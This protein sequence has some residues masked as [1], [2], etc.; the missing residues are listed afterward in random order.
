MATSTLQQQHI[1]LN[2]TPVE[3]VKINGAS[4]R[5]DLTTILHYV[6]PAVTEEELNADK[7]YGSDPNTFGKFGKELTFN[8]EDVAD[9]GSEFSL[10]KEGFTYVKHASALT[11]DDFKDAE[12]T[13]TIY[14]P[15]TE[16]LI[17]KV[18][19]A[20]KVCI[21]NTMTRVSHGKVPER[22]GAKEQGHG[23][24][25][26]VHVDQDNAAVDKTIRDCYPPA[27]AEELLKKRVQIVNV[28]RP[29]EQIY[30]DPFG[31]ADLN[32]QAPEDIIALKVFLKDGV[33]ATTLGCRANLN[34]HWYYKYAQK[35]D[36]PVLFLQFDS[37]V[38]G[39]C[40]GRVPHSA[41]KDMEYED[42]EPRRSIEARALVF[43]DEESR[44]YLNEKY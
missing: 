14:R 19:G 5:R 4:K 18:T 39:H 25:Y 28:W 23:Q 20:Y 15:E 43:Y 32:T 41:F 7:E 17:K 2:D 35:P 42:G 38:G 33:T 9:R 6:D 8:V 40:F 1:A 31:I 22:R 21:F 11:G 34:H 10:D 16:E 3:P 24:A 36:E 29:I 44:D 30:R 27:E 13:K 26:R 37:K 12:K